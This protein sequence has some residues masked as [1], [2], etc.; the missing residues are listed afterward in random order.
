MSQTISI[1]DHNK[2]RNK[3][4]ALRNR[5]EDIQARMGPLLKDLWFPERLLSKVS[6]DIDFEYL[7]TCF[8]NF[9]EVTNYFKK[10]IILSNKLDSH[11]KSSPVLLLGDPGLGKTLYANH[12]AKLFG[13]PC[14]EISMATAT[15]SFELSG[16]S[17]H[18]GEGAPGFIAQ[19]LAKSTVANPVFVIDEIDKTAGSDRYNPLNVFYSLLESH[20]AKRFKDEAL[21]LEIDASH[22]IWILTANDHLDINSPILSRMKRFNINQPKPA[23]MQGVIKSILK[24]LI[25]SDGLE[26]LIS[27]EISQDIVEVLIP[28]P[29]R[30]IRMA[31]QEAMI[32]AIMADR[33]QI[34][35]K[36][37]PK[38]EITKEVRNAGFIQL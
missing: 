12:L 16:S 23:Q 2:L 13:L 1:V 26:N 14:Y 38:I 21:T 36:D 18:W 10:Q 7:D 6:N 27:T 5:S 28:H 29:P 32:T 20:T 37:L 35:L 17:L 8:P 3:V 15:A 34:L 30:Q 4:E 33:T 9:S 11:F 22:I 25:H 31:L 19:S 24:N